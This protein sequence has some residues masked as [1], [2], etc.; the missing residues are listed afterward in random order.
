MRSSAPPQGTVFTNHFGLLWVWHDSIRRNNM[1]QEFDFIAAEFAFLGF[2]K[3]GNQP[4]KYQFQMLHVS[5][6]QA[7]SKFRIVDKVFDARRRSAPAKMTPRTSALLR[8]APMSSALLSIRRCVLSADDSSPAES[9]GRQEH[10][11]PTGTDK[12]QRR[13]G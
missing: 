11:E 13:C 3:D 4:L 9:P 7:R 2:Q 12:S 6:F 8:S 10:I 5:N 1:S